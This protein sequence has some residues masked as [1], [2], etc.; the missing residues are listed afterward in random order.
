MFLKLGRSSRAAGEEIEPAAFALAV[1][2]SLQT[3]NFP[4]STTH[5]IGKLGFEPAGKESSWNPAALQEA[6]GMTV[7]E[8]SA[9]YAPRVD[10]GM[11]FTQGSTYGR[12]RQMNQRGAGPDSI[13]RFWSEGQASD[14]GLHQRRAA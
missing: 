2:Y 3:E 12:F 5:R 6:G 10:R 4:A 7:G 1:G 13:E 8:G 11:Q 9:E 14:V